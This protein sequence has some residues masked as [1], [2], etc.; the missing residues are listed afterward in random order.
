[1][2]TFIPLPS[3]VESAKVLDRTRLGNQRNEAKIILKC[4]LYPSEKGWRN[5]PAV[6]MWSG[7]EAALSLYLKAIIDEWT[8]RGHK[9]EAQKVEILNGRIMVTFHKDSEP[10]L[11]SGPV[12]MPSW[13]E[14]TE[15]HA[16]HRSALIR[17][18]PDWYKQFGWTEPDNLP[19]IWPKGL[20]SKVC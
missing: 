17:K 9:N 4:L 16:A 18:K 12:V 20:A 2:Q 15:F 14:N 6:K 8:G 3:F 7:Y 10:L 13:M 19:Y 11:L 1:M 5:H